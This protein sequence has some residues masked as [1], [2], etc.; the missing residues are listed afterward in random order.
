MTNYLYATLRNT[1]PGRRANVY[2]EVGDLHRECLHGADLADRL[3]RAA[4][5]ATVHRAPLGSGHDDRHRAHSLDAAVAEASNDHYC[6]YVRVLSVQETPP[7]EGSGMD[8]NVANS[9][10]LAWR[11]IKVAPPGDPSPPSFFT[12]RNIGKR[13]DRL[14]LIFQAPREL[15]TAPANVRVV[16]DAALTRAFRAGEGKLDGFRQDGQR[17]FLLTAPKA[18]IAGLQLNPGQKGQVQVV[19]ARTKASP[20]GPLDMTITQRSANGTDGGV[21]LRLGTKR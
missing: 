21:T 19:V 8:T 14:S 16:L 7:T 6:L 17:G 3:H 5:V 9:N 2:A 13:A 18:G 20:R 1:R 12:V 4:R 11:N 10:S 15:L